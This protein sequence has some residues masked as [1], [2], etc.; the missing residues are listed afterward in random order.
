MEAPTGTPCYA[1]SDGVI[2]HVGHHPQF[3]TN[4]ILQFSKSGL[5]GM[6][7]IDPLWAFYAHLSSVLVSKGQ[8]VTSGQTIAFTGHSGNANAAA[9][10]LHFEIRNIA[11]PRP[12]LGATGRLDPAV[13]L[14][15][16]YLVCS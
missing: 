1:I 9:P 6:S 10:H 13:I 11:S 16:K 7:P 5:K 12:G 14:G 4:I 2:T 8:I 15:S 3:G